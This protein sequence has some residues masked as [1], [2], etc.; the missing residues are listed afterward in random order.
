MDIQPV[1]DNGNV[2]EEHVTNNTSDNPV[3]LPEFVDNFSNCYKH[4]GAKNKYVDK[5]LKQQNW[6]TPELLAE[7]N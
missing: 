5:E 3:F 2:V 1:F 7:L 4:N 6:L